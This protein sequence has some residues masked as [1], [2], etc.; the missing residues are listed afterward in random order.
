MDLLDKASWKRR[1]SG[2]IVPFL[3][4]V[5]VREAAR[6][7]GMGFHS[8]WDVWCTGPDGKLKWADIG[9]HNLMPDEGEQWILEVAFSEAQS[10][11]AAFQIGLT[12][13]TVPATSI[14]EF[15]TETTIAD[16]VDGTEPSAN[17]YARQAVNSDGTDWT[18]ALDAGDYRAV[19]KVVTFTAS[20][21]SIPPTGAV[22]WMFL[23]TGAAGKLVS[24]VALSTGRVILD[25]DSLNTSIRVKASE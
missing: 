8:V 19:S 23:V 15:T 5:A 12:D 4:P 11:P 10:V 20:G 22:D 13:E 9:L 7:L 18:V 3:D 21:G 14:D 24:A 1:M 6:D 17:G 16:G 25:G 2:L